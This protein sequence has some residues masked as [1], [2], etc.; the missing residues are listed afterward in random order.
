MKVTN[1][2]QQR[3]EKPKVQY[4]L[5]SYNKFD[6][7]EQWIRITEGCPNQCPYCYEP[8]EYKIFN[9]PEIVRN[10]VK[11][12][13]MNLLCK[14]ECVNIIKDLGSKKVNKKLVYYELVCGIDFR[15][16]TQEIAK[17]L[18]ENHFINIRLAWDW[19]FKDQYKI[20][21]TISML[22]KEGY[23]SKDIMIFMICNW[24]ISY[25]ECLRKMDLCK[26]WRVQIA[27]CYFDNQTSPNIIPIHWKSEQIKDFRKRCRTHNQMVNFGIDPDL[28]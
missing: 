2:I 12:M 24:K 18:K 15:F 5:G 25:N 8:R 17:A 19:T 11:I 16:M 23:K 28:K 26:I 13:D 20:K 10:K 9:I 4:S 14:K 21:D 22:L 7:N 27:D 3:L 6:K 1:I